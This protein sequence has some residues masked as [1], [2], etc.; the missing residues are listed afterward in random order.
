M[1]INPNGRKRNDPC[2]CGSGLKFKKCCIDKPQT[3]PAHKDASDFYAGED[4]QKAEELYRKALGMDPGDD[5]I[6]EKRI[7]DLKVVEVLK[8]AKG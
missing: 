6:I 1:H 5:G 3:M 4:N 2:P 7:R 8:Q